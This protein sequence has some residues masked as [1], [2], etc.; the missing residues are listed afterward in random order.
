[1]GENVHQSTEK[2]GIPHNRV[3]KRG[4]LP[5]ISRLEA[6][7][8][9]PWLCASTLHISL[10][11]RIFAPLNSYPSTRRVIVLIPFS[12]GQREGKGSTIHYSFDSGREKVHERRNA[13]RVQLWLLNYRFSSTLWS[14]R[15]TEIGTLWRGG[16]PAPTRSW[17]SSSTAPGRGSRADD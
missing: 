7:G 12:A 3:A 5:K 8:T 4:L 11:V 2:S 15:L 6:C 13:M 16:D 9:F 10:T 14:I 1:M 17:R